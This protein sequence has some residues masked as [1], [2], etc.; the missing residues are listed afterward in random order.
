MDLLARGLSELNLYEDALSVQEASLSMMRR[1]GISEWEMLASQA[2]LAITY[3]DLGRFEEAL[4]MERDVYSGRLKLEGE[5]HPQTLQAA[6]NYAN[7]LVRSA[8][9]RARGTRRRGAGGGRRR[10]RWLLE[11]SW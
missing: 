6:N 8:A 9:G 1:L 10:R 4:S 7:S 5:E 3:A 11:V 2:N